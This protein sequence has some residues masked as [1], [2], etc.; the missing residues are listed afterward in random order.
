MLKLL[1]EEV[2]LPKDYVQDQKEQVNYESSSEN[3]EQRPEF[4]DIRK[5]PDV[6]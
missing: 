3:Q 5:Q 2:E 1:N 6:A 4:V